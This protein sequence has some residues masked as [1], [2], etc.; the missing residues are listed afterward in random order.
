LK[1]NSFFGKII[2]KA[3]NNIFYQNVA[4]IASGAAVARIIGLFT[5]PIITRLYTP[6]DYGILSVFTSIVGIIGS[7][8]TLRYAVTIPLPEKEEVANNILR[9]SFLITFSLSIFWTIIVIFFGDY[10]ALKFDLQYVHSY[11][12]IIPVTFFGIGIYQAL[13][14]WAIRYKYFK[15]IT[16]TNISQSVSSRAIKIGLGAFGIRPLGLL[17][18][19]IASQ[20]AGIG[21]FLRKLIRENP[22]FFKYFPWKDIKSAAIRYKKF[23]MFQSWSQVLL[24]FGTHLPVMLIA[25]FYGAEVIGLY[26]LAHGMVS[27]PMS[28]LGNAVSQVYYAEIA[29]YG[30][31]ERRKILFSIVFGEN[32]YDAGTYARILSIIILARFVISPVMHCLNLLEKQGYQLLFNIIRVILIISIFYTAKAFAWS[33][34]FTIMIYSIT[35]SLFYIFVMISILRMLRI[36]K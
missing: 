11:L 16:Q 19:L 29:S 5:A 31:H 33:S 36:N 18:G 15:K 10:F 20:A 2:N 17:I 14:N 35:I 8:A 3:K 26:G 1:I 21:S 25:S 27:M 23:P 9:L 12:W 34:K 30:K 13:S 7:L 32:W 22:N 28:L 24:S 4:V 6:E